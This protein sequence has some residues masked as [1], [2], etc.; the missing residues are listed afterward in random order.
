MFVSRLTSRTPKLR[1]VLLAVV[2][3]A[4]QLEA[5]AEDSAVEM[6]ETVA[7]IVEETG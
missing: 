1:E 4:Q 7:A 6:A 5:M 3:G 2:Q